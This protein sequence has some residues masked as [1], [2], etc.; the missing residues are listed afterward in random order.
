MLTFLACAAVAWSQAAHSS[1]NVQD[2]GKYRAELRI[3]AEGIF[4]GEEID[5]EF[6]VVDRTQKDP[7]E[8]GFRGV[9]GIEATATLTMPAMIG[10]PEARPNVHREGVPGDYGVEIYFPHGGDF[11]LDLDLSIP[12]AGHRRVGFTIPVKDPRPSGMKRV[13]PYRLEVI[14][15]PRE[16][17]ANTP[18]ELK[19][20]V[21]DAKTGKP[22][23]AF[24]E[25]HTQR[26]HLM[27]A[28]KDLNWFVHEHPVMAPDGTWSI[29]QVFPAGGSYWVYGDVAATSKGSRVL[30]TQVDVGGP[31]PTWDTRLVPTRVSNVGGLKGILSSLE[32]IQVGRRANLQVKLF[33][34]QTGE[35][36]TDTEPWL[37]A[38]AHLMI[39]HSDGQT[40]VHS[41]PSE[42]AVGNA[43]VKQGRIRFGGRFPKP[44]RYKVYGQFN[45][46]G[47]VH[48]L[49]FVLDVK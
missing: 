30:V 9:G 25:A 17:E 47:S 13:A 18:V 31:K 27:I 6:R 45:W 32:P 39:F 15:W 1:G 35:L 34:A 40:V 33:D 16:A 10:M 24:D 42:D 7:V 28:S 8:A 23:T 5:L 4:A 46:H 21:L 29:S 19:L 20:R 2:F 22:Q 37:G 26:F 3:P 49:G 11:R 14:D 43:L 41:Y 48:T 38:A 44:G 12:G 36:A